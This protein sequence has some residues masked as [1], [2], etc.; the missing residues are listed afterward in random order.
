MT[1]NHEATLRTAIGPD[2]RTAQPFLARFASPV[3]RGGRPK[4]PPGT[5]YT[6]VERETTDDQ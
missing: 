6:F 2:P 1:N 5:L 3:L 4:P